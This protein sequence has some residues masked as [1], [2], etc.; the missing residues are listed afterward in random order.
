MKNILEKEAHKTETYNGAVVYDTS[1]DNLTDLFAKIGS[2]RYVDNPEELFERA[3]KEDPIT[4]TRILFYA[5]DCRGGQGERITVFR[6]FHEFFCKKHPEWGS[7]LIKWFAEMGRWK[8]LWDIMGMI[9]KEK[10]MEVM[11]NDTGYGYPDIA[12]AIFDTIMD[13][14][15]DDIFKAEAWKRGELAERPNISMLGKWMP[16][17]HSQSKNVR[18]LYKWFANCAQGLTYCMGERSYRYYTKLLRE[19]IGI[20]EHNIVSRNY[21]DIDYTKL[22]SRALKRYTTLFQKYD[23]ERFNTLMEKAANP[24]ENPEVKLNVRQLYPYEILGDVDFHWGDSGA[25]CEAGDTETA[26]WYQM[27]NFFKKEVSIL[28][29]LDTSGSMSGVKASI[30]TALAIYTAQRNPHKTFKDYIVQFSSEPHMI[31]IAGKHKLQDV[32]GCFKND[33]SDTNFEG[34]MDYLL[35]L[36][37]ENNIPAEEMPEYLLIISDMQFNILARDYNRNE[38]LCI[39]PLEDKSSSVK[40][41]M[42]NRI[43]EKWEKTSYKLPMM[44]YW[45]V[46]DDAPRGSFPMAHLDGCI[47]ISGKSPVI[48][49]HLFDE[50]FPTTIELIKKITES[51][52]YNKITID[53]TK[54]D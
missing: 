38:F 14:F 4:A 49:D 22:P 23:G 24:E 13:Q 7:Q 19:H 17:C 43:R 20:V 41:P 50:K 51:P 2:M 31:S 42:M 44:I 53:F 6:I 12:D 32:V 37:V 34:V 8:D 25:T 26:M 54:Q 39:E 15:N 40:I 18:N 28:S 29:V 11:L 48:F 35:E 16:S 30:A 46:D 21:A 5:R 9:I 33:N 3:F 52:R 27:P 1:F 47:Y 45:N 36:A 10:G